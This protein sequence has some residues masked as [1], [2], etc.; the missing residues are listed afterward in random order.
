MS[1]EAAN[2]PE[3]F[4]TELAQEIKDLKEAAQNK[5]QAPPVVK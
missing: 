2:K 3:Q 5:P 1:S 4:D